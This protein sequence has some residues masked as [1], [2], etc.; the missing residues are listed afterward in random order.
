MQTLVS[1]YFRSMLRRS[2]NQPR[3][4]PT[5]VSRSGV[6]AC[7]S[8]RNHLSRLRGHEQA[9]RMRARRGHSAVLHQK[10]KSGC[11]QKAPRVFATPMQSIAEQHEEICWLQEASANAS[12]RLEVL[13]SCRG[14]I[15]RCC[16]LLAPPHR[17]GGN[18]RILYR[19]A[20]RYQVKCM[21]RL[22]N[23][24]KVL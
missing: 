11:L 17:L 3:S 24:Q 14:I 23:I 15:G 20:H 7:V 22:L 5:C 9:H 16:K 2:S 12:S 21:V 10:L 19:S 8:S 1:N 6:H 4:E 18:R 13:Q